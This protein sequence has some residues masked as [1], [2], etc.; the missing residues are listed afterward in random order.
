MNNY[1]KQLAERFARERI[2]RN[3]SNPSVIS[4]SSKRSHKKDT[5]KLKS[6]ESNQVADPEVLKA[7]L[8]R[9]DPT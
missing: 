9:K 5:E 7:I 2:D 8:N 3:G 6:Y 1:K 4:R